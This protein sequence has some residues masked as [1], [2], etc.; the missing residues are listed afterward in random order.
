MSDRDRHDERDERDE[1]VGRDELF[2]ELFERDQHDQREGRDERGTGTSD[3]EAAWLGDLLDAAAAEY[4]PDGERLRALVAARIA[5]AEDERAT[6]AGQAVPLPRV[7]HRERARPGPFPRRL[8]LLGRL[9]LAGIPA[10]VALATIGA[11]A[12]IAVGATATITMTTNRGQAATKVTVLTPD[13]G[14][15]GVPESSQAPSTRTSTHPAGAGGTSGPTSPSSHA[16]A[17]GSTSPANTG[18]ATG[19]GTNPLYE[20]STLAVTGNP[21]WTELDVLVTAKQ[22]LTSLKVTITV[23]ACVGL[24]SPGDY[25]SGAGNQ[26]SKSETS[27]GDGSMTFT[28]VLNPGRILTSASGRVEFAAQFSHA[29]AGWNEAADSYVAA[30]RTAASTAD[31][32]VRGA[33]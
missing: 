25:D 14:G 31:T 19:S 18:S 3:A 2:E 23:A 15:S 29:T 33:Y 7:R 20:T 22:P 16:S 32:V 4:E 1:Y 10:G 27:N 21:S 5:A 24:A 9:G 17:S 8:R 26:F 13:D 6:A 30:A 12:A 28:F 11:A